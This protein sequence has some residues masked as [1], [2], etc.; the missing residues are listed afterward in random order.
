MKAVRI[1]NGCYRSS[2]RAFLGGASA[3]IAL[4][5]FEALDAKLAVAAGPTPPLRFVSWFFPCGIPREESWPRLLGGLDPVQAKYSRLVGMSNI[6]GGP[7]HAKGVRSYLT[8]NHE[9][10]SFDQVLGDELAKQADKAP[11]H[12][13][14]LGVP[15]SRCEPGASCD[16][17]NNVTWRSGGVVLPKQ[18]RPDLA[19]NDLFQGLDPMASDAA[20]TERAALQKSVLD[21]VLEDSQNLSKILSARDRLKLDEYMASIRAAEQRITALGTGG[22]V[23]CG[24]PIPGLAEQGNLFK[25]AIDSKGRCSPEQ[26]EAACDANAQLMAL[27]LKCDLTRVIS[28]MAGSGGSGQQILGTGD[29]YHLGIGHAEKLPE[30]EQVVK[31]EMKKLG[32][33]LSLLE[34]TVEADGS[35]LLDNVVVFSS[36][37]ICEGNR[38][39]HDNM[40][41]I[42]AGGL[43]GKLRPGNTVDVGGKF[44]DLFA[45]LGEQMGAPV[46][47]FGNAANIKG[48]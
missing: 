9:G 18:M 22:G 5:A 16:F 20:A 47:G 36:S 24:S 23:A 25:A 44:V 43:G 6:G 14:Q 37:E 29:D 41:V 4:P 10:P 8:G 28:F 21:L 40:P 1:Q 46:S 26:L 7:D 13:L 17:M 12:S 27:A 45:Y 2:R 19:F 11:I 15:D 34:G 30:F 38:H 39:N 33:F 3:L 32:E 42:L 35:T 48:V 31:W